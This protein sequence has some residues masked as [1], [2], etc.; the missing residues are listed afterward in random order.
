MDGLTPHQRPH[1]LDQ[2]Y[3]FVFDARVVGLAAERWFCLCATPADCR[4]VRY[5]CEIRETRRKE[6]LLLA[7]NLSSERIAIAFTRRIET[8]E[9]IKLVLVVVGG[10]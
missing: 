1:A 5:C 7:R 2:I 3:D 9:E 6:T 10:S 4:R 8:G